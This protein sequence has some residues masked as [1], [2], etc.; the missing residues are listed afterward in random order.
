VTGASRVCV[1]CETPLPEAAL[2]CP[3]CGSA[4]P[5]AISQ[6]TGTVHESRISAADEA[7]QRVRLQAALGEHF[8]LGA[9]LGRGGFAE[10]YVATDLKLKRQVAVKVLRSDLVVSPSLAERF[11]REAEAVA[12]LRH[13]NIVAI[14]AVGE[15]EALSYYV[16]PLIEGQSLRARLAEGALPIQEARRILREVAS[17]LAVAHKAGIIHRD[18]KPDNIMLEGD[19]ARV[20]VMDF[21]IAKALAT[22]ETGLTGTGMIVGTPHYMSPEQASGQKEIDARSDL[23]SLGI[24]GYQMLTGRLPFEGESAQEVLVQHITATP[25]P[26]EKERPDLPDDLLD[27]VSKCLAKKPEERWQSAADLLRS[28]EVAVS[29]GDVARRRPA[30]TVRFRRRRMRV[31]RWQVLTAVLVLLLAF[32]GLVRRDLVWNALDSWLGVGPWRGRAR[33]SETRQW[34]S[35]TGRAI[36]PNVQV[37]GIGDSLMAVLRPGV[38]GFAL[39]TFDGRTWTR[40]LVPGAGVVAPAI[41]A[42]DT[43]LLFDAEW[44]GETGAGGRVA[45]Y[46]LVG[47]RIL[48]L[49]AAPFLPTVAWSDGRSTVISDGNGALAWRDR[50]GWRAQPSARRVRVAGFFGDRLEH[51]MALG[52]FAGGGNPD[53]VLVYRGIAWQSID[54]RSDTAALWIYNAGVGFA[55]GSTVVV[56]RACTRAETDCRPLVAVQDSPGGRWSPMRLD[57]PAQLELWGVWGRRKDD[58]L[59]WGRRLAQSFGGCD[60]VPS[61]LY[62]ISGNRAVPVTD[63]AGYQVLGVASLRGLPAVLLEDGTVWTRQEDVWGYLS[64][65]PGTTPMASSSYGQN[66]GWAG[67]GTLSVF[68]DPPRRSGNEPFGARRREG[69]YPFSSPVSFRA[70]LATSR[71]MVF[72]IE[73]GRLLEMDCVEGAGPLCV[74]RILRVPG[75]ALVSDIAALGDDT[76]IAVGHQGFVAMFVRGTWRAVELPAA[77]R[78]DDYVRVW[79][80]GAVPA[81][82]GRSTLLVRRAGGRWEDAATIPDWLQPA[83][84]LAILPGGLAAVASRTRVGLVPLDTPAAF[85]S[86]R[87]WDWVPPQS[88]AITRLLATSD[89]RLVVASAVPGDPLQGGS[90]R[91][92]WGDLKR[93]GT[94]CGVIPMPR[95]ADLSLVEEDGRVLIAQGSGW[96]MGSWNL[97]SLPGADTARAP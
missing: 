96:F 17:A 52:F 40:L 34:N 53:S 12:K 78:Q 57:L 56:G 58:L 89:G 95:R 23:Y 25:R 11:R 83:E 44:S 48:R 85:T 51:L 67:D 7:A 9:L 64:E 74:S 39:S 54:P 75:G 80:R 4:T 37:I 91:I 66:V 38:A 47:K 50:S 88:G 55:D 90:L 81:I 35:P 14:Y 22:G 68:F 59:V 20:V 16:M 33:P 87:C 3:A 10:V 36:L 42:R 86:V 93:G 84:H 1:S 41:A 31:Q 61:C 29:T 70:A 43:L 46:A 32:L 15:A 79:T 19:D 69:A 5:T 77:A 72:V 71:G 92:A 26:L 30:W 21:G 24:V 13:P 18:I 65:V 45:T 82:L 63:V 8:Q 27:A 73:D 76:L 2:Y 49:D 28:L 62:A 6:E 97:R 94:G 60:S